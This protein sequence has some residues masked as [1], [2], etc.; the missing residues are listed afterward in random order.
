MAQVAVKNIG[1]QLSF[2]GLEEDEDPETQQDFDDFKKWLGEMEDSLD[3][4]DEPPFK[5]DAPSGSSVAPVQCDVCKFSQEKCFL[6]SWFKV[7]LS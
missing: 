1:K 6:L 5:P 4:A 7:Y 2:D 3:N